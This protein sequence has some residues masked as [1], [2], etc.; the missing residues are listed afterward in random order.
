[1]FHRMKIL[2]E[3]LLIGSTLIEGS[4]LN[5]AEARAVLAGRTV[6][7]HSVR[8]L[9]ELID[10]RRAVEWLGRQ[11]LVMP[12]LSHDLLL[13]FHRIL[14]TGD[15]EAGRYKSSSNHTFRLDGRRHDF[16]P[17]ERVRASVDAWL[18]AFNQFSP[19]SPAEEPFAAAGRLYFDFEHTH[20]FA[21]GNGR[22]GRVLLAYWLAH[23]S[24]LAFC[25]YA[26]DKSAHLRAMQAADDGDF[27]PL[28]DF[29]REHCRS[30]DDLA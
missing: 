13:G 17:P 24:D 6:S 20:P 27:A 22:I 19:A 14:M 7:G 18:S 30:F 10:Y 28:T 15:D 5:E 1:M 23:C 29:I 25:F 2:E 21:D 11:L 9:R 4:T 16:L 26:R 12:Y 3:H 8:E